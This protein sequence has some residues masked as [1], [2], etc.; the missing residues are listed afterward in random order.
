MKITGVILTKDGNFSRAKKSLSFCDEVLVFKNSNI[1]DFAKA[2]NDAL[3]NA[4][5]EWVLFLDDDEVVSEAL[6]SEMTNDK[7]PMLNV[8]G[9]YIRRRDFMWEKELKHGESGEI[10]LLRLAKK[11]AGTWKRRVHEYWEVAGMVG[12]LENPLY[13]YP[14]QTL[15]EFINNIDYFSTI[16]ANENIKEGKRSS[17]VK[18]IF[19][20]RLKFFQNWIVKLGFLDGTQGS[21][22]TLIMSFHSFLAWSKQWLLQRK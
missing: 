20:P 8:S 17:L 13:H 7:W 6:A 4:K 5:N 16:H 10:R 3:K 14:H 9:Y 15:K 22:F 2:R 21:V 12:E 11:N 19:W 1:T 18:I